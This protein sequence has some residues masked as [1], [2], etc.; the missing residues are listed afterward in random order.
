MQEF[1]EKLVKENLRKYIYA[2]DFLKSASQQV[3]ELENKKDSKLTST[4]GTAPLFGG[5]SS[6]EDKIININAKIEMLNKNIN[7]NKKIVRDVEYG[8]KGLSDEEIDI[9]LT[10]YGQRQGWNKI[11][12]LKR[13]YHYSKTRLYEIARASLEHISYRLYGDA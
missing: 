2:K 8:L 5:G 3:E 12:K 7:N 4:Y 13:E 10:I 11:D 9:T 1:Y 6:Q